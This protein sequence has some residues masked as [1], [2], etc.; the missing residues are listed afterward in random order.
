M[1]LYLRIENI[2]KGSRKWC[3]RDK[4]R[5]VTCSSEVVKRSLC[6]LVWEVRWTKSKS[7]SYQCGTADRAGRAASDPATRRLE[8]KA[9][10][11]RTNRNPGKKHYY[12]SDS[13]PVKGV[14]A[15]LHAREDVQHAS[16]GDT[17]ELSRRCE[18]SS[19]AQTGQKYEPGVGIR[20]DVILRSLRKRRSGEHDEQDPACEINTLGAK[21]LSSSVERSIPRQQWSG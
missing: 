4:S 16:S 18:C 13:V 12:M 6:R 17:E 14:T 19:V 1:E 10:E 20:Y 11:C 5:S 3:T 21:R 15:V 9:D 8:G 2:L 7:A